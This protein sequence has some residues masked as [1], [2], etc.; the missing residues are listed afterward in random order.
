M[1]KTKQEMLEYALKDGEVHPDYTIEKVLTIFPFFNK[2]NGEVERSSAI[3][4]T[5]SSMLKENHKHSVVVA[6]KK[7]GYF[8]WCGDAFIS[9]GKTMTKTKALKAA[10][11][12]A[13][14]KQEEIEIM[15][16]FASTKDAACRF[17]ANKKC[18]HLHGALAEIDK[19]PKILDKLEEM[20]HGK[21]SSLKN[22]M[23]EQML[24]KLM[25]KKHVLL[26]GDKGS[27]KTYLSKAFA[28]K[29]GAKVFF[30]G[31]NEATEAGDFIGEYIPMT[32]E[33]Q[34]KG[35]NSLFSDSKVNQISMVWKDGPLAQAFRYAKTGGKAIF[36]LDEML[37]VP[38]RELSPLISALSPDETGNYVLGTRRAIGVEDGVA[39][40]EILECKKEN[41]WVIGTT[42]V[43]AAYAI[44]NID[45]ALADR[46]R[47]V[48]M[49]SE[50]EQ[51]KVILKSEALQRKYKA[52]CIKP[53]LAFFTIFEKRRKDGGFKK[54]CN[55]RHLV[56]AIQN[57][58]DEED[59][60]ETL[61][62][63]RYAWVNTDVD[64]Q[65]RPEQ[66][67]ELRKMIE[68]VYSAV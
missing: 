12:V 6:Y 18:S 58:I 54:V 49:N 5:F 11:T 30:L 1:Q 24:A 7:E 33:T 9:D 23:P 2:D 27:G 28:K 43:G 44:D 16:L 59:I 57:S 26:Q 65:P 52:D 37:R 20:Y 51:M 56:E 32:V 39:Q 38:K 47:I 25:Y 4:F 36:V 42:N 48:H 67:K 10:K 35:Q 46:L 60:E 14:S 40:E 3:V 21:K 31:G 63:T 45:E 41:F 62:E 66:L 13:K 8:A 34:T 22:R 50:E 53:L 29:V 55:L 64:G 61:W 17:W 19:N 68:K 15:K